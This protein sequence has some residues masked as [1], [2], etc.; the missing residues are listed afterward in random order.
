MIKFESSK[1][2]VLEVK[3]RSRARYAKGIKVGDIVQF[4]LDDEG[5]FVY[6]NNEKMSDVSKNEIYGNFLDVFVLKERNEERD[7]R[8]IIDDE[9]KYL[10]GLETMSY[11]DGRR[12][13]LSGQIEALQN[14]ILTIYNNGV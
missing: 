5:S 11:D 7:I 14:I 6:V 3:R 10:E 13:N 4:K 12:Q 9:L 8:A 2:E 1:Y